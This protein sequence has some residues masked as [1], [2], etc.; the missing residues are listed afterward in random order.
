MPDDGCR[1]P[2]SPHR[3]SDARA[4]QRR[5]DAD[6]DRRPRDGS[7]DEEGHVERLSP[8]RE[9]VHVGENADPEGDDAADHDG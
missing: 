5:T 6:P 7:D 1:V 3:A 2:G 8:R 4:P 9:G